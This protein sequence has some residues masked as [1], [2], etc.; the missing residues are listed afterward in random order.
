MVLPGEIDEKNWVS[1][2]GPDTQFALSIRAVQRLLVGAARL[3]AVVSTGLLGSGG[4]NRATG[5]L[6]SIAGGSCT[7]GSSCTA[8]GV[9][10]L[11]GF[12]GSEVTTAGESE[13]SEYD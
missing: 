2:R 3:G 13:T 6:V 4:R 1:G 7:A 9:C 12:E 8:A 5:S 11:I 10:S